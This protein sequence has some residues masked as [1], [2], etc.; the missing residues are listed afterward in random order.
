MTWYCGD[1]QKSQLDHINKFPRVRVGVS[2]CNQWQRPQWLAGRYTSELLP[3]R[4]L[5]C[6]SFIA[7]CALRRLFSLQSFRLLST[8]CWLRGQATPRHKFLERWC[9]LIHSMSHSSSSKRKVTSE[10]HFM[11]AWLFYWQPGGSS[12]A[13]PHLCIYGS[14]SACDLPQCI[15]LL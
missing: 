11:A 12:V 2:P 5:L 10:Q 8:Y 15:D 4:L 13:Q 6:H 14:M 3:A 7:V 1:K 9:W